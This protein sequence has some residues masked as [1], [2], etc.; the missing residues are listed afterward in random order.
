MGVFSARIFF[1]FASLFTIPA[2]EGG[3]PHQPLS[4]AMLLPD[5]TIGRN[6]AIV[7]GAVVSHDVP[8][9]TVVVGN[10][11]RVIKE[12]DQQENAG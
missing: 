1:Y 6:A 3:Y 5:I 8:Q 7:A 9:D 4:G 12:I 11:A 2:V 10:P